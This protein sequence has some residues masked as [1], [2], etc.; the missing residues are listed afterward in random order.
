MSNLKRLLPGLC[1]AMLIAPVTTSCAQSPL[2]SASNVTNVDCRSCHLPGKSTDAKDLS[3]IYANPRLHH[4]I[5]IIYPAESR[6]SPGF[7]PASGQGAGIAFFDR[8][9][10]ALPDDNEIQ[11]FDSG[12]G[13][14]KVEC[15]SCHGP[16]GIQSPAA[17]LANSYYLR[18]ANKNSELCVT[19][20]NN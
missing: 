4:P 15:A 5:G 14:H 6:A 18:V 12:E 7:N 17:N 3:L 8:N 9:G 2:V 16:H 20:H 13:K 19:C 10:N 1:A 11:L